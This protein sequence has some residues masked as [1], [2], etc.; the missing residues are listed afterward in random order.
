MIIQHL[1]SSSA[2][3]ATVLALLFSSP[4][5]SIASSSPVTLNIMDDTTQGTPLVTQSSLGKSVRSAVISGAKVADTLDLK[6]ERVSDSLRDQN[7]CDPR[8]NRRLFDNGTRKDGTPIGNPVLG[9]LC[10]SEEMSKVDGGVAG[11]VLGLAEDS[12]AEVLG[13]RKEE[14]RQQEATVEKLVGGAFQLPSSSSNTVTEDDVSRRT[15]NKDLYVRMRSYSDIL[16]QQ[17]TN[18]NERNRLSRQLERTWGSKLLTQLAPHANRDDFVSPFP[19]PDSVD[20]QAYDEG[21][22]LDALGAVSVVLNKLRAGGL[23]GH[24]EISIPEDD[25]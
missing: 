14:M 16:S 25:F 15:Y 19:K 9:A 24:W 22:L 4:P 3:F 5:P 6:W 7:K 8:T 23:I 1:L 11:S 18:T 2:R 21:A 12:A 20:D 10:D 13:I 17:K